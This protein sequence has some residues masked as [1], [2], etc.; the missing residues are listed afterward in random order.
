MVAF[1]SGLFA[2]RPLVIAHRGAS[3]YL[4]EHTLPAVSLAYGMGADF[5]EQDVVLSKD[6][7]PVVLHDVHIDTVTDVVTKFPDR[8]RGD[9]RYYAID[10]TIAE[11]KTLLVN[12]RVNADTGRRV[13]PKRFPLR[14]STF[15]IPTLA[16]EIEL[17]QGMNRST[18][19]DVGIYPEIKQPAWH[20]D[21]G[22]DTSLAVIAVLKSYGYEDK[23]DRCFL[24]CF[25]A[26][27]LVR[28]RNEFNVKLKLIQLLG[29]TVSESRL[30]E[31]AKY[32]DGIGPSLSLV[33]SR[34]AKPLPL[35]S[36][37]QRLGLTVHPYTFRR[38]SLPSGI[39][40]FETLTKL[41]QRAGVDGMFTDFPDLSVRYLD[42]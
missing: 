23:S 1:N 21:Q 6:G 25:E 33:M 14:K 2:E 3:G 16:E 38:D 42:D 39:S 10:F 24:Q 27:E 12:E 41:Y 40:D 19:R 36:Q 32:A 28:I 13:Y 17:I 22:A 15:R 7:T 26:D 37:A 4:P 18:G 5:I 9:G 31:I 20:R 11:L 34:T 29:K 30:E 35:L 8:V